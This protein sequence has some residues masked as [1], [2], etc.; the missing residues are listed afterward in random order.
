MQHK[1]GEAR[2]VGHGAL[3]TSVEEWRPVNL[4]TNINRQVNKNKYDTQSVKADGNVIV[5]CSIG[6]S[7]SHMGPRTGVLPKNTRNRVNLDLR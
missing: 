2:E 6:W 5:S 3:K 7:E 4:I 1:C